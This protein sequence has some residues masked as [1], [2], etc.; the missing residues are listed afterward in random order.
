M[1]IR[2]PWG[3]QGC[4]GS[5]TRPQEIPLRIPRQRSELWPW[6]K[7]WVRLSLAP[8]LPGMFRCQWSVAATACLWPV[9]GAGMQCTPFSCIAGP[10]DK[11]GASK[12]AVGEEP[13]PGTDAQGEV[14][15]RVSHTG[16]PP[17]GARNPN[18]TRSIGGSGPRHC[19]ARDGEVGEGPSE[20]PSSQP[21]FL[22]AFRVRRVQ[23]SVALQLR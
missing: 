5:R 21:S 2:S 20:F 4:K 17:R 11:L 18:G 19:F 23:G 10:R 12:M 1:P 13:H 6:R 15:G 16:P 7:R 9:A 14:A 3:G 8:C 22:A